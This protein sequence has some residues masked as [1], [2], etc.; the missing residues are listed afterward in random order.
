MKKSVFRLIKY[1]T[2]GVLMLIST[3]AFSQKIK[4][5]TLTRMP[6]ALIE[7]SGLTAGTDNSV[8]THNDSG[9]E[10]LLYKVNSEG[11][12]TR[13]VYIEKA[14]NV[15]WEDL[16]NDY[17]GFVYIADIGNNIN[18]RK[19]L[20]IYK[21]SHPDSVLSDTITPEIIRFAY[22]NQ[23]AFPPTE[24]EQN[25]DA[26]ALVAYPDSLFI[27]T[28][29][30]TKPYSRYTYIYGLKNEAGQQVAKLCDSLYLDK[31]RRYWSWVTGATRHPY[32]DEVILISHR[33]AWIIQDFRHK[34]I[35]KRS[36]IS[37]IYSQK[38]AICFD[39]NRNIWISNEKFKCLKSKLKLGQLKHKRK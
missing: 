37:G 1:Y 6:D 25:F 16:A 19:D 24:N 5:K 22:P 20:C 9:G 35:L 23:S 27:F 14:H 17:R 30:R 29:N 34:R 13:S 26:E 18:C 15:D 8:W 36:K 33:K 10:P 11:I 12:I 38:E 4:V 3:F 32:Q 7:T 2:A 28:K 21:I 39:V 31:T